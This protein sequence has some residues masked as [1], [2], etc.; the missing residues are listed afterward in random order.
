MANVVGLV[1]RTVAEVERD[2][3]LET[4]RYCLGNRTRAAAEHQTLPATP[5][6]E[7]RSRRDAWLGSGPRHHDARGGIIIELV[8]QRPNGN[9][10]H[11]CGAGAVTK[12]MPQ[13]FQNKISFHFGNG[14]AD[15][16]DHIAH[17]RHSSLPPGHARLRA[18]ALPAP[19]LA[20]G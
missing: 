18:Q 4:V 12:T 2:L 14:T 17:S 15:Q 10:E 9:I 13:R 8:A 7:L 5:Q 6:R 1:G 19:W 16:T 11:G 3:I 20:A